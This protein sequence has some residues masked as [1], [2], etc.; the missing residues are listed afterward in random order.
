VL[1]AHEQIRSPD[2]LYTLAEV[3]AAYPAGLDGRDVAWIWRRLLYVLG[4]VRAQGVSHGAVL[5]PH[6]LIEPA[7]HKLVLIN[8]C[9]ASDAGAKPTASARLPASFAGPYLAWY[10]REGAARRLPTPALDVALAARC[11]IELLGG[12]PL[13]STCPP[14]VEP[15]LS[16]YFQR[17][18][19]VGTGAWTLLDEFD[20]L[21]EILWGPRKFREFKMP[22]KSGRPRHR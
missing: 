20:R 14:R 12:D 3:R 13:E 21:I 1:L 7:G 2:E 4:F 9:F 16:R 5:P 11:M 6:V 22:P 15:A 18:L 17:C 19:G 8:W 10:R